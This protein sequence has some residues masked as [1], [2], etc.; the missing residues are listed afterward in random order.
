[1]DPEVKHMFRRMELVIAVFLGCWAAA[2]A[3]AAATLTAAPTPTGQQLFAPQV[4]ASPVLQTNA[5]TPVPE[6]TATPGEFVLDL[7]PVPTDTA[8]PT[9]ELPTE[10]VRAPALQEWDGLPTYPA[11]SRP[12]YYFRVEFD[13][14]AWALTTDNFG[15]PALAHRAIAN[16]IIAPTQGRGLP[17]DAAVDHEVRRIGGISY[18]ISSASVNGIKQSV[19]YAAGDGRIFTAFQVSLA[20]RPDECLAEAETVLGTLTSV[21]VSEA[22]PIATP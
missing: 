17:P 4:L 2:C 10:A 21:Q 8:L 20:D 9:L 5:D 14:S 15:F 1:M 11:E 3:P 13:P 19:T 6:A 7:T 16:C 22:T 12:D 18:Q